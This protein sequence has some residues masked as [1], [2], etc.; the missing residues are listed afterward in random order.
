MID[1]NIENRLKQANNYNIEKKVLEKNSKAAFA[2]LYFAENENYSLLYSLLED[3]EFSIYRGE[4]TDVSEIRN[5]IKSK[6]INPLFR[7]SK[8]GLLTMK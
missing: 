3:I 2:D 6:K 1:T 7:G 5:F 8:K 4:C